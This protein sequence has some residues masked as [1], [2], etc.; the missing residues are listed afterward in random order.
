M[1]SGKEVRQTHVKYTLSRIW[2]LGREILQARKE[3]LSPV[4]AI[5][6]HEGGKLLF[7]G[8]VV[9]TTSV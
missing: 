5:L 4:E 8:K 6:E 9:I 2:R 1:F 7:K 3:K